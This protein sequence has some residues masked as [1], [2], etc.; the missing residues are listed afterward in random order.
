MMSA[1]NLCF[2]V[3]S[4]RYSKACVDAIARLARAPA[5]DVDAVKLAYGDGGK[6]GRCRVSPC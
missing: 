1:F 2:N 5:Y 4:R 6:A 3:Y